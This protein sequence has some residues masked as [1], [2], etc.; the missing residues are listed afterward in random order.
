MRSSLVWISIVQ[1]E[2]AHLSMSVIGFAHALVLAPCMK[3]G[4]SPAI[5]IKYH[6]KFYKPFLLLGTYMQP[7]E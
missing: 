6:Q 7:S 5:Y 1:W 3:R 2:T 4:E